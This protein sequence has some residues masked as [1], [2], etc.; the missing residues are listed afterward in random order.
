L[1]GWETWPL[2]LREEKRL[3]VFENKMLR[4]IFGPKREKV[5]EGLKRQ[6]NITRVI[7]LRRM[8]CMGHLELMGEKRNEYKILVGK[9]KM[10][11][12][13]GRPRRRCED[14]IRMDDREKW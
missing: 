8:R 5:A 9:P 11:R 14:N 6:R 3:R 1:Y 10:T 13:R 12:P 2:T 7:K 4:R